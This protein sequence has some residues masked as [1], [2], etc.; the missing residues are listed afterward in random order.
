MRQKIRLFVIIL[1]L[2]AL[3]VPLTSHAAVVGRFSLVTGQVDLLKQG[4]IP[5]IPAKLQDGVE[6]GDVIRTKSQGQ[7][8]ADHGGRLRHHPGAG[9]PPGHRRLSV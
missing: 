1:T 3:V 9:V 6:I 2:A 5:A 7:G 4:K 8:P